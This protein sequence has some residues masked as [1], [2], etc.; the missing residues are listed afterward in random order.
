[1]IIMVF[2]RI[3]AEKKEILSLKNLGSNFGFFI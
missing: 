1:M 2:D 3:N